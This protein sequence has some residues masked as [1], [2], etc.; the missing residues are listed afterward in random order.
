MGKDLILKTLRHEKTDQTP[1]V[2][3]AGVHAGK[4]KGYTAEEMLQDEDKLVE[5]L[6]E[7]KK[8]YTPDGMPII[9]DLQVEAEILG[10]DLLWA[11]NNPPSV[12]SHPCA[13]EKTIP[14]DCKI[15]TEE[16]GRLPMILSAMRRVKAEIGDEVALY[17][18]ICG[19]F[20]LAS[21][22]RGTDIFMD[23]VADPEYVKKLVGYCSQVAIE[24]ARMYIDAGMD[25]IAVVDPLVSQISPK[26]IEKLYPTDS[27]LFSITAE[28]EAC[29]PASSYAGML[30]SRLK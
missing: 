12:T 28:A 11:K 23:M 13:G 30:R 24:M 15:P 29:Y 2:P 5:A 3:F 21:H 4:L 27:R 6:L 7:T 9:F 10:C 26:H 22:L 19:P 1:W 14:C 20:T 16:S 25:V 18:L 8:I 17:G